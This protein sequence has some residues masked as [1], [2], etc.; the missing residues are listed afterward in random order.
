VG[1]RTLPALLAVLAAIAD[2]AGAHTLG[3]YALLAAVPF[4]SVAAL[5]SFG[6]SLDARG[7]AVSSLQA[8]LWGLAVFLL[9]LACAVRS[10]SLGVPPLAGSALIACLG[11]FAIKAIVAA[12]PHVR[13][14]ALR[15]AKP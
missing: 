5:V 15:P 7:D 4:A 9:V 3:F 14:L 11:V 12:A 1:R 8:L 2:S 13:R 6:D 10:Q